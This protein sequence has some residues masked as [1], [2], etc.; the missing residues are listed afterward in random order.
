MERLKIMQRE[1]IDSFLWVGLE[2]DN[3]HIRCQ[4][5]KPTKT[6]NPGKKNPPKTQISK[7]AFPSIF[8][9]FA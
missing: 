6:K 9:P 8:W 4:I 2:E 7:S 5:A 3:F 1:E